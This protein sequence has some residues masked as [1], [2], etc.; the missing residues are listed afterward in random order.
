MLIRNVLLHNVY[1]TTHDVRGSK[2]TAFSVILKAAA[3]S[4]P[5][6]YRCL[7]VR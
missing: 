2:T 7:M 4:T 6:L 3:T 5:Y 1:V